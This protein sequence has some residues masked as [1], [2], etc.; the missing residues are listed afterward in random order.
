MRLE[1]VEL[2]PEPRPVWRVTDA[3][4]R[5]VGATVASPTGGEP[6][7]YHIAIHPD[8]RGVTA[9]IAHRTWTGAFR[10]ERREGTVRASW[11]DSGRPPMTDRVMLVVALQALLE[12]LGE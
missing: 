1:N 8:R 9:T 6:R 5:A 2:H 11:P 3:E 12:A 7:A 10:W 4:G